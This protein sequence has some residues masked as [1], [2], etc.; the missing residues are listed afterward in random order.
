MQ[1][2]KL[3]HEIEW[4]VDVQGQVGPLASAAFAHLR[5]VWRYVL[6]AI[7]IMIFY[8]LIFQLMLKIEFC[9]NMAGVQEVEMSAISLGDTLEEVL[10]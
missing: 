6:L 8:R 4:E 9:T 7:P 10:M 2:R 3:P 5:Y 1:I